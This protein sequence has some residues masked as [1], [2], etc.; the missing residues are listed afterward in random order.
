MQP[1]DLRFRP[2]R[3]P[4]ETLLGLYFLPR[5]IDKLRAE[6]PGGDIGPY[7]NEP[8]G[9]SAFLCRRI[10]IDMEELRAVVLAANDEDEVAAWLQ[11]RID[12]KKVE[13]TNRKLESLTIERLSPED[14]ELVRHHHPVLA[15]RPDLVT[16]LD[17]FEAD[18]AETYESYR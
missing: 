8:R 10:G 7:L 9:I 2:P 14:Q 15:K 3:G 6:M 13:E 11:Q 18:D 5:T 17:I 1:L 12:P 16:F 4:R